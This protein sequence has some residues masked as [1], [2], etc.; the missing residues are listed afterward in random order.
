MPNM[1]IMPLNKTVD[2]IEGQT[3]LQAIIAAGVNMMH[4]CGGEGKCG[5]CHIFVLDGRKGLSKVQ[6]LENEK[7]DTL[8]GVGSKSRL[9]C[10]AI[11]GTDNF[12]VELLGFASGA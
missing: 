12:S 8:V 5:S 6:R 1:T 4:K 2:A 9:A 10:Q 3:V 11:V 7:L